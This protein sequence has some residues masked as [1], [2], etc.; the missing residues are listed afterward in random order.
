MSGSGDGGDNGEDNSHGAAGGNG[1]GNGGSEDASYGSNGSEDG[2]NSG[3]KDDVTVVR[4]MV[5]V[6]MVEVRVGKMV[7]RIIAAVMRMLRW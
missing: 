4:V 5:L 6:M 1:N 3:G 7:V 2:G